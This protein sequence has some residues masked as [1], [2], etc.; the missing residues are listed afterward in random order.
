MP[1]LPVIRANRPMTNLEIATRIMASA[2][3]DDGSYDHRDV[4]ISNISFLYRFIHSI[5]C[6]FV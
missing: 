2:R 4:N 1:R 5:I 6:H 3:K